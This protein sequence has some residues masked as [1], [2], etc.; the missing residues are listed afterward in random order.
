MAARGSDRPAKRGEVS[1]AG[2]RQWKVCRYTL[3]PSASSLFA[4]REFLRT[5]LSP[6]PTTD[7]VVN[8]IIC[9]THEACKNAVLHNPETE[10]PVDVI[11][12][13]RNGSVVIE[14]ADSGPGFDPLILP[15]SP[16]DPEAL[17]G[18]GFCMI[19]NLMDGV[20]AHTGGG[21]TRIRMQKNIAPPA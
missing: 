20:E 7:P 6:F 16:P 12:E 4:V 8:D 10:N 17:A 19:Y 15:P 13:V 1:S 11:C 21:G 3:E 2:E 9:A 18:R 5:T 14:V